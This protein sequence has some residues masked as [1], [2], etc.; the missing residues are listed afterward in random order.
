MGLPTLTADILVFEEREETD[1]VHF[2]AA[3]RRSLT[4]TNPRP[5]TLSPEP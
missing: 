1:R 4:E 5:Q 3:T 2:Q